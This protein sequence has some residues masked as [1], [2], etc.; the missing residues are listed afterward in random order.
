MMIDTIKY[1][2]GIPE[3]MRNE[4]AQLYDQ[5]FG[6]KF[7]IAVRN[8]DKR[9]RLLTDALLLPFAVA[10]IANGKLAGLAGF[11][12]RQGALTEGM[13]LRKLIHHS[14]IP[15]GLWA[16]MVFSL[17]ERQAQE[18]ELLMDGIAVKHHLR[19]LG[20]GTKLL[21]ELRQYARENE[22][23]RIRLDVIDTNPAAKR[24]YE[25]HG[26]IPTSTQHF[27][28]LRK[29]LGFGASTTMILQVE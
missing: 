21:D 16:A 24:L 12:A 8:K 2:L 18:S 27:G 5:A 19:G 28:Y 1:Q 22:Y 29:F 23:S 15:G 13:T 20:I 9:L 3:S 26:F 7:S 4:A 6:A 17:Y 14:G 10:A 25:R 11:H